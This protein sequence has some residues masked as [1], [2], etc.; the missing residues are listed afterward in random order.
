MRSFVFCVLSLFVCLFLA[1]V[2][3]SHAE[4]DATTY[5]LRF[6]FTPGE[7]AHYLVDSQNQFTVQ[8][9]QDKEVTVNSTQTQKHYRVVAVDETGN[10]TLE[11]MI[12][13]VQMSV[14]FN[15]DVPK[16][17]DSIQ[18]Q[19]K[20]LDQFAPIRKNIGHPSRI[21]YSPVGEVI[22]VLELHTTSKGSTFKEVSKKVP[23]KLTDEK[24]RN[25]GFLIP[26]PEQSVKIGESWNEDFDVEVSVSPALRK[27]VPIRRI[28]TLD[29]VEDQLAVI[30]FKTKIMER[31]NDPK[32]SIQLIQKTPSGTIKLDLEKGLIISQNVS[33]DKAQVGVFNGKGAMRAISTLSETLVDPAELAQKTAETAAE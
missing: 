26:L 27:K 12:D 30:S 15:D 22:S 20:D 6:K 9:N 23:A 32:F 19:K 18:P 33:L 14:Q 5:S 13:R 21:V 4:E 25:L 10:A 31:L 1:P 17:F 8:L 11:T 16:T 2:S 7:F 29:S 3:V 24:S 28:F